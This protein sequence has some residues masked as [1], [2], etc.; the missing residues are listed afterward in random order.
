[1]LSTFRRYLRDHGV[2]ETAAAVARRLRR[3]AYMQE[4]LIVIVGNLDAIVEP[5]R[6]GGL[7]LEDLGAEHLPGLSE[8]NHRRG[9]PQVD[10]RFARYVE[11]GFHGFV[12]YRGEEL[13]GYYWWVDR[14]VPTLYP[15]LRKLGLGIELGEGDVYGSDFYVL[16]E[17]RGGGLAADFLF[18]VERSLRDRGYQR[19]WGYVAS[20]N[21]PARWIYSTRGYVPMWTVHRTR[22]LMVQRTTRE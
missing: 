1:M 10:R 6:G 21:R 12:A 14:D 20:D 19:I 3:L 5:W 8:L 2:R 22:V 13:L 7:R 4:R 9:R 11:Q 16:D 18:K 17:H 15:D